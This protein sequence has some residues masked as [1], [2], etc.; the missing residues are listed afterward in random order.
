MPARNRLLIAALGTVL[1]ASLAACS[2][3]SAPVSGPKV[4][5]VPTTT[6]DSTSAT[7]GTSGTTSASAA[8]AAQASASSEPVVAPA[9]G[10]PARAAILTAV[11]KGL[12][13]SGSI[14]VYQLFTQGG[15]AVGDILPPTGS[16]T[17][18]ALTGGPGAWKLVW[19]AP[20]GSSIA[21]A[22]DLVAADPAISP[23]LVAK[24]DF[25]M[26]VRTKTTTVKAAAPSAASL[27]AFALKKA[28][29]LISGSYTGTFTVGVTIAKSKSGSWWGMATL[30]PSDP[31]QQ[32]EPIG[33]FGHYTGSSWIG[34]IADSSSED[35]EAAFF[36]S[37]VIA[38]L[39]S[40]TP[41]FP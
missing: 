22:D 11:A 4:T 38:T 27:K 8:A 34:Q 9:I 15:T 31:S 24:L 2:S 32:L 19:H 35:P 39:K 10:S 29:S 6:A 28:A 37:D 7:S 5:S 33:V 30:N 36:P 13:F 16:R 20:F 25:K 3:P 23:T 26:V 21:S 14:T 40:Q 41:K 12:H 18:F 1:A 17:F